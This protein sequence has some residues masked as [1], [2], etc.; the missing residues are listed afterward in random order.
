MTDLAL[1]PTTAQ[2]EDPAAASAP[3]GSA[4][5]LS[6]MATP[7]AASAATAGA[8]ANTLPSY[9]PSYMTGGDPAIAEQL[10]NIDWDAEFKKLMELTG[11]MIDRQL[12]GQ[13]G[14]ERPA[15]SSGGASAGHGSDA[16]RAL[17]DA[18]L[19]GSNSVGASPAVAASPI[20]LTYANAV[21]SATAAARKPTTLGVASTGT[22][23]AA[24]A[25]AATA[26]N[27]ADMDDDSVSM[28][29]TSK[30]GTGKHHWKKL[31]KA[32]QRHEQSQRNAFEAFANALL[33]SVSPF[34]APL[35]AKCKTSLPHIKVDQRFGK[36]GHPETAIAQFL[37]APLV[38]NYR[39]RHFHD[40]APG[41]L[42]E[43]HYDFALVLQ[44]IPS[45]HAIHIGYGPTWKRYAV[46]YCYLACREYR[47]EVLSLCP[48]EIPNSRSEAI[49]EDDVVKDITELLLK[50]GEG[51]EMLET[52]SIV[53]AMRKRVDLYPLYDA[54]A[55]VFQS[56]ENYQVE[57]TDIRSAP[58]RFLVKA[59]RLAVEAM[60][61]PIVLDDEVLWDELPEVSRVIV[62]GGVAASGGAGSEADG[63]A[64]RLASQQKA[65]STPAPA[66]GAA[67]VK[68]GTSLAGAPAA[69]GSASLWQT[70]TPMI[71]CVACVSATLAV[72]L[73]KKQP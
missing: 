27:M 10:A 11:Q 44:A 45:A 70:L 66:T 65:L 42:M 16:A 51:L 63:G 39:P 30:A 73:M 32:Q 72:V 52:M 12:N 28:T 50:R 67:F 8:I 6:P 60:P 57:I 17:G 35:R 59:S 37:V 23:A 31:T 71:V 36:S 29:A 21:K 46:P 48:E 64:A 7:P 69:S 1:P 40:V 49:Y 14:D 58:S 62:Q 15:A 68:R 13:N 34:M 3:A 19:C 9:I 38:T 61:Q 53:E 20:P 2:P 41:E 33:H 22:A 56:L 47:K 43:F 55:T 26:A 18:R 25:A 5:E 4:G 54:F 24:A